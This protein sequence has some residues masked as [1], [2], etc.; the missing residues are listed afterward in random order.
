MLFPKIKHFC[1]ANLV[2]KKF[3]AS[4]L[5]N[6]LLLNSVINLAKSFAFI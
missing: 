5:F 1:T 4:I 6:F 3:G 2:K